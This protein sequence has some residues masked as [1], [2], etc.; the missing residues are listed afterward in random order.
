MKGLDSNVLVRYLVADEPAQTKRAAKF[1]ETEC[2]Q[3][4]PGFLNRIVLCE[5]VWVL[6]GAYGY[7]RDEITV[8]LK[9]L[10]QTAEFR[11]EDPSAA[12][13]AVRL[14]ETGQCDFADAYLAYTNRA[15]GCETTVTFD[16][17]ASRV[18]GFEAL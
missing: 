14:Y 12:W 13:N 8:P 15:A 16:Q 17:K 5:L 10:L 9:K 4:D 3:D 1:I 2:T 18:E 6:R 7:R 11:V